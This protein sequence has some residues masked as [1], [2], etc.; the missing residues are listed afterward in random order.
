[1]D[2][3]T[4]KIMKFIYTG[5]KRRKILQKHPLENAKIVIGVGRN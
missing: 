2:V 1:M 4:E 5:I 3:D